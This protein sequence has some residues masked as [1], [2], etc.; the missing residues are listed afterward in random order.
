MIYELRTYL[1][2]EGRM[3]NILNRFET[4]TFN[5]FKRHNINVV[6][7]WTKP[8]NSALIYMCKFDSEEAMKKSWDAFRADPEWIQKKAQTEANGPIVSKVISEVLTATVFSPM[9]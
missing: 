4:I 8:D 5:I 1:I 7:F 3:P 9:R 2:P 6:G